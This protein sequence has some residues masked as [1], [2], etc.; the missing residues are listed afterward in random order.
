M[1]RVVRL[2]LPTLVAVALRAAC[3]RATPDEPVAAAPP[4]P[5]VDPV[6]A[7]PPPPAPRELPPDATSLAAPD[8]QYLVA[9]GLLDPEAELSADLR[10]HPE[11]ITCKGEMGGTPG[12]HDPEAIQILGRNRAHALFEDGHT[13]GS[14]DLAFTVRGGKI[15]WDVEKIDCGG[16]AR[17]ANA[18]TP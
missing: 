2:A 1:S 6:P 15:K 4:A 13:Q 5:V 8:R 3:S 18:G 11:L 16:G 14:V 10:A 12:F 17:V 9:Q 7:P